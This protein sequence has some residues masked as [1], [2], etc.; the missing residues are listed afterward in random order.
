MGYVLADRLIQSV[1]EHM[2][3]A[4]I[5]QLTDRDSPE[6][7]GI[8]V[9][10][11]PPDTLSAA[12]SRHYSLYE[13]NWL[14]V[15]TDVVIEKDVSKVFE[16][17]FDVAVTDRVWPHLP[18]L[19]EDFTKE[20]PYCAG[21]VFSKSPQFWHQVH[22]E[23]KNMSPK[24]QAWYGDQRALAKVIKYGTYKHIV[25]PGAIYQYPPLNDELGNA[26]ITHWK[27]PDRKLRLMAR[28]HKE[29]GLTI[30]V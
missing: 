11:Q 15:D 29:W 10:R 7:P 4:K 25:L 9:L 21:A 12:R 17:D 26:A 1:R 19:P 14:F 27:G 22:M 30:P 13:G 16:M 8:T 24:D 20:M 18:D 6:I 5:A 2:P 23:V 28:I 3:H